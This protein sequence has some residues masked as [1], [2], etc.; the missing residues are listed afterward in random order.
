LFTGSKYAI[1]IVVDEDGTGDRR[2]G[3]RDGQHPSLFERLKF[4]DRDDTT[5]VSA[6]RSS[7]KNSI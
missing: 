7:P 4:C 6:V 2:L 3:T 1:D 5:A